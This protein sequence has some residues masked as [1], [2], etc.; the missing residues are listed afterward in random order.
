VNSLG[1]QMAFEESGISM[2]ALIF[3]WSDDG[4]ILL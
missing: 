2:I 3:Q 1:A 4:R